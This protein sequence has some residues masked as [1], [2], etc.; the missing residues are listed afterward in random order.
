[1]IFL[2]HLV[3]SILLLPSSSVLKED[4]GFVKQIPVTTPAAQPVVDSQDPHVTDVHE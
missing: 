3:R 2:A 1:M 4:C